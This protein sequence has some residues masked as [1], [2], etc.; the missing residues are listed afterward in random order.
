MNQLGHGRIKGH[1]MLDVPSEGEGQIFRDATSH[2]KFRYWFH[3]SPRHGVTRAWGSGRETY[4]TVAEQESFIDV[5]TEFKK[6]FNGD[7]NGWMFVLDNGYKA[8]FAFMDVLN[9]APSPVS[10]GKFA[11]S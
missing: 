11:R 5:Q 9:D 4:E 1:I 10:F 7:W 6:F 2:G 3:T 8:D